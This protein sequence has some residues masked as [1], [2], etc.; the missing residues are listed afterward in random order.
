MTQAETQAEA[1]REA[2]RIGCKGCEFTLQNMCR[3]H[4]TVCTETEEL[5]TALLSAYERGVREAIDTASI[6]AVHE[7]NAPDGPC[8][9]LIAMSNLLPTDKQGGTKG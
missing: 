6:S 5:A 2:K 8:Q 4:K 9:A 1:L 3:E 7:C